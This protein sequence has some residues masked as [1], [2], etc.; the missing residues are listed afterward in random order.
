MVAASTCQAEYMALGMATRQMHWVQKLI[1]DVMGH[2]FIGHLICDNESAIK[3]SKNDNSNRRTR[4]TDREY[5]ITNPTLHEGKATLS[6]T[7][8]D[9]Q[10]ADVLTKALTPEKQ[11]QLTS[12]I[13]GESPQCSRQGGC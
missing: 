5:Y 13:Q 2:S 1:E 10:I 4:H 11:R 3:V 6:W 9:K 8:T 12:Q 7:S